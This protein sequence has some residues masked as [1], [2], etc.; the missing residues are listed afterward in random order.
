MP[1]W[2]QGSFSKLMLMSSL[3]RTACVLQ[4]GPEPG[5]RGSSRLEDLLSDLPWE[6][7]WVGVSG[8]QDRMLYKASY[9]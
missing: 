1:S 2:Q 3:R 6:S 9:A 8:L 7:F 4:L 5:D